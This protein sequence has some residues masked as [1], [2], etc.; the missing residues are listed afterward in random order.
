MRK[1]LKGLLC[2][3]F[4]WLVMLINDNPGAALV[5]II[6]QATLIGWPFAST[7]AWRVWHQESETTDEAGPKS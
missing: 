7:W 3:L 4:P 2:F 1:F 5:T 6:M